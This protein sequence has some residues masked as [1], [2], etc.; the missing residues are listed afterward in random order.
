MEQSGFILCNIMIDDW[1]ILF[2]TMI[3]DITVIITLMFEKVSI[4]FQENWTETGGLEIMATTS[5]PNM[6]QILFFYILILIYLWYFENWIASF[7]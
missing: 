5:F 2:I 6:W 7:H 3:F 1:V 4:G